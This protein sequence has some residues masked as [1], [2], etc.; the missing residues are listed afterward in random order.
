MTRWLR[1]ESPARVTTPNGWRRSIVS[2][3]LSMLQSPRQHPVKRFLSR[4]FSRA[5]IVPPEM[6]AG[7]IRGDLLGAEQLAERA[8][9]VA[10]GERLREARAS[11]RSAPLLERLRETRHILDVAHRRLMKA[12]QQDGAVGPAGDWFL[13]NYFVVQEHIQ[14]VRASLPRGYYR[15]LPELSTGSLA[16]YPRVYELA[17][18]L[19]SHTEGRIDVDNVDL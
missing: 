14:E 10:R 8:R 5:P 17:I 11:G 12:A 15:E 16:G 4:V 18:T 13:D 6:L 3:R 9:A 2:D 1:S 19:I 7:P